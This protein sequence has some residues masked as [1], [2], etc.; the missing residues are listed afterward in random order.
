MQGKAGSPAGWQRGERPAT[1]TYKK[2]HGTEVTVP[3]ALTPSEDKLP[4]TSLNKRVGF[5]FFFFL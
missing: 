1:H 3:L 4:Q 5:V 2:H